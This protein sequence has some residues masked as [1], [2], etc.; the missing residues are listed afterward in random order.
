MWKFELLLTSAPLKGHVATLFTLIDDM[1]RNAEFLDRLDALRCLARAARCGTPGV[2]AAFK[3][4]TETGFVWMR[5]RQGARRW[6][7]LG[8]YAYSF[9]F[10]LICHKAI[11]TE[12]LPTLQTIADAWPSLRPDEPLTWAALSLQGDLIEWILKEVRYTGPTT[13]APLRDRR[14][15]LNAIM[16]SISREFDALDLA[17]FESTNGGWPT[18]AD[19]RGPR[20]YA[21]L[22]ILSWHLEHTQWT[23]CQRREVQNW[24]M[25]EAYPQSD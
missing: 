5:G 18:V 24:F 1:M 15:E 11:N 10:H 13:P 22:V 4:G 23:A 17:M 16:V 20:S 2:R 8:N 19:R 3:D 12:M 9:V 6:H 25:Q 14:L 21:H 7:D